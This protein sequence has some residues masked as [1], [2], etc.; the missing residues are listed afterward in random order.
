M[1]SGMLEYTDNR[2]AALQNMLEVRAQLLPGSSRSFSM[3]TNKLHSL[4]IQQ[5][6]LRQN[7]QFGATTGMA[8]GPT[9][10]PPSF[11]VTADSYCNNSLPEYTYFR[12]LNDMLS[13]VLTS[14]VGGGAGKSG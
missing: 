11:S 2:R 12:L 1:N 14:E 3:L 9:T 7:A 8:G 6:I 13:N 5:N 4:P 10:A